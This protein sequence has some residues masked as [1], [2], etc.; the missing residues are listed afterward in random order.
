MTRR[1]ID[2]ESKLQLS[3]DIGHWTCDISLHCNV[4]AV[5]VRV[6]LESEVVAFGHGGKLFLISRNSINKS[7][8]FMSEIKNLCQLAFGPWIVGH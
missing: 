8:A 3:K 5:G 2:I 6:I 4:V 1:N 7:W